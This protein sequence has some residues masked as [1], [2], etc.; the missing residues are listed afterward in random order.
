MRTLRFSQADVSKGHLILV[1]PSHP[2]ASD[3]PENQLV[4]VRSNFAQILLEQQTAKMLA[5][6]TARLRCEREIV[7]V[8]GY[9]TLQAQQ[10][11]YAD[12]VRK[13]G[14]AFTQKYVAFPGC[15]EH[16]TGLAIDLAENH[17]AIDFIRPSFPNGGICGDFRVLCRKFGFIERYPAGR[18]KITG[19]AHEPWHFRYV[20]Y[21]HSEI[22]SENAFTLE[23]YTGYLKQFSYKGD[24]FR[25]KR[26][27]REFEIFYVP[28]AEDQDAVVEISDGIPCQT[29]GNNEN[30]VV[31]T[32][33]RDR[34]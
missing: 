21:P 12:S 31:V 2:L 20:G 27:R 25:W 34:I 8:S 23:Q 22:I 26:N 13:H 30:G 32:L 9:R 28:V 3:V 24:H 15:S 4:P 10:E 7:P 33:W 6:I 5:E 11:I 1:N 17:H 16:Q 19:I 29:S 14:K 18:E